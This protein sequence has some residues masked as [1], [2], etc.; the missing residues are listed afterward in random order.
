M[1]LDSNQLI[2]CNLKNQTVPP[3]GP[4]SVPIRLDFT[5]DTTFSLDYTPQQKAFSILQGIYIDNRANGSAIQLDVAG[6]GQTITCPA[7][8]QGYFTVLSTNPIKL[9]FTSLGGVAL[10]VFLLNFP[11]SNAVWQ[12]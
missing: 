8:S 6:T 10:N 2:Q 11:V 1:V 9:T 5:V 12:V 7:N 4:L 3:E